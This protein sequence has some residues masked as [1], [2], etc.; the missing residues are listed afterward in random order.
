M[1]AEDEVLQLR[2]ENQAQ[3]KQIRVQQEQLAKQDDLIAQLQQRIQVLEKRLAKNS[4]NSH[5]PSS[6]DRFVRQPKSLRTRSGKKPGG[7]KGHPGSTL[8]V[9]S[10]P[11]EVFVHR[12]E[13]CQHCQQ[14]LTQIPA[15]TVERRQ[16]LDLPPPRLRVWEHQAEHKQCPSCQRVTVAVFP[17]EVRAPVQYGP[18]VGAIGV[19]LVQQ[20]LL[21]LARTC[22][23]MEDLLGVCLS[24]GTLC[25]LITRCAQS[26][27]E[28][29]QQIKDALMQAE[30][31]HQ[32]ETGMY[33]AGKRQWVHVTCTPRLTHYQVHCQPRQKSLGG[34]WHPAWFPGHL[35]A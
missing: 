29:E 34:H 17:Q 26:L 14:D 11:D 20:Q 4:G 6:S 16:V 19:Y 15:S 27:V 3:Q 24:E 10:C 23:V 32:D 33:V 30:V 5:L 1:T 35:G 2:A 8:I 31:L 28:V 18:A 7:Q 22:E 9:Q 21:P 12:V 13:C 25:E